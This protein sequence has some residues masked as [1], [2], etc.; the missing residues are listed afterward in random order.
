MNTKM[1]SMARRLWSSPTATP[2]LNRRNQKEWAR[3]VKILG[4][5][6]NLAKTWTLPE[7]K[8]RMWKDH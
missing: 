5:R 8:E 1:L 7:L 3:C 4:S 6:W 2:E